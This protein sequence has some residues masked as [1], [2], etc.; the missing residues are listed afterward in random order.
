MTHSASPRRPLGKQGTW[1]TYTTTDGLAALQVE[2]IV[3]DQE[4]YLWFAT[5]TGGVS[6]FDGDEFCTFTTRD[7]L[8]SDLVYSMLCDRQGRLWFGT[9]DRGVCWY[10]GREFHR[11]AEDEW[12]S[13]GTISYLFEDGEGRIWVSGSALGYHDG[14]VWRDL[15]SEYRQACDHDPRPC[16]GIAQDGNGHLW[17]GGA[18]LA[19]FDGSRFYRYGREDGL[20][21]GGPAYGVAVDAGSNLWV[22][23]D[24]RIWRHDGHTFQPVSVEFEGQ[25][26]KIQQDREGRM[27]F[28]LRGGA[29]GGGVLCFDGAAFHHYSTRDGL[30][31][32]IV[33]AMHQDREGQ[34]WFATWGRGVSCH[35]PFS[36]HSF[37][38]EKG[39]PYSWVYTLTES[40]QGGIWMSFGNPLADL[41][42]P[43]SIGVHDG[44]HFTPLD[45]DPGGC[46]ALCEDGSGHL[47]VG[48]RQGLHCYDGH[49]FL[50]VYPEG[51][52]GGSVTAIAENEDLFFGYTGPDHRYVL[53]YDGQSFRTVYQ[54][55][56]S[57]SGEVGT[58]AAI[59]LARDR[60][61]WFG[62]GTILA[63]SD[64]GGIG[65]L[66]ETGQVSFLTAEDGLVDDRVEDLL[67]DREGVL[68]I[69]TLGG[70]S[71]F[72]GSQFRSFSLAD[73]LPNNQ[74]RCICEDRQG[75]LWFGTDGGVV[76]Y[77]GQVFQTIHT[78]R[79]APTTRIIEDRD[80]RLWFATL[81]GAV[82]YTPGRIA[83]RIRL[84]QVVADRIYLAVEQPRIPA[85]TRQVSFEYRGMSFRTRPRDMFYT[86]R[87]EGYEEDWR[88]PVR[89]MRV[90]YR[91]LP[92]GE[93]TFQVRAVD[94]DLNYSE[95]AALRI[96]VVPDPHM[97]AMTEALSAGGP[98]GEF[99]G[100]SPALTRLHQ[101]LRQVA[102]TDAT[103]LILG[104]T[105][106]GKG[107]AARAVHALSGRKGG[108]FITVP[109]GAL[110]ETLVE[111]EL[112][113]H[114]RGA[115]TG[116]THRKL[117]KVE[118][119]AEGTLFLDEIGDLPLDAQVKL[120]RLLEERTF[121]RVGGTQE[122]TS[123]GRIVAATNRD[124]AQMVQEGTFRADLFFR[125][126]DFEVRLPPLRERRQDIPLLALYFLTR[127]AAHLNKRE[128]A[129]LSPEAL[130]LLQSH[131]WPGNVRELEHVV[132]R[133]VIVGSGPVLDVQD[134]ALGPD[135][136]AGPAA[137]DIVTLQDHER[138]YIER[139]LERTGGVICGPN[140]AARLLDIPPTTLYSRM[141]KLGIKRR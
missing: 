70:I 15:T 99:V 38:E 60:A 129:Q 5:C 33:G 104:E 93:Y 96:T 109:C 124:L 130:A 55:G 14:V 89:E 54:E 87:L 139:V 63:H 97:A 122:L 43:R 53:C 83:P 131:N 66:D 85:S 76:V 4:G 137:G 42:E 22:G 114:E 64:S 92:L 48:S 8:C 113:G 117:G 126:R 79:V 12:I 95:T 90:Y 26:R 24:D 128:I 121:E 62:R 32:D 80:G 58:I 52:A 23:R 105:G 141:K 135:P 59:V 9:F 75:R 102:P 103:V 46:L 41:S 19:R 1:R 25:V 91:D 132:R 81:D 47:W 44:E 107:L 11:F 118:V 17:F 31:F 20:L 100:N 40:R 56:R 78:G 61:L 119:A 110:P 106:T 49:T 21:D 115:F 140:G 111:S 86:C 37:G 101:Q 82:R 116:A 30:A 68:W 84:L 27:W 72:D 88:H 69:A 71:R 98:S 108:P 2:H 50:K 34:F 6:R 3:E 67:E 74:V 45:T 125:L 138:S 77:D 94:R 73:G 36:I 10:D 127:S 65:R 39:W 7:G 51:E 13:Q 133:A 28:C 120:L 57:S 112:F 123:E 18:D 136:T 16:W 35:D 134:I 29:G